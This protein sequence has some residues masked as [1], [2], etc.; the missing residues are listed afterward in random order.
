MNVQSIGVTFLITAP[1]LD[2][3]CGVP[4]DLL[5]LLLPVG[6]G[7]L[8]S[9]QFFFINVGWFS[10]LFNRTPCAGIERI[11]MHF[12]TDRGDVDVSP[13][14]NSKGYESMLRIEDD[15]S[16]EWVKALAILQCVSM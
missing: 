6:I 8:I 16:V 2:T 14:A 15:I 1:P 3:S 7:E 13:V 12:M 4:S 5:C 11:A 10:L 9:I